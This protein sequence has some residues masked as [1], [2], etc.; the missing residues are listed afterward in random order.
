MKRISSAELHRLIYKK[1]K[2]Y[3]KHKNIFKIRKVKI[4]EPPQYAIAVPRE[5]VETFKL[6]ETQYNLII[7]DSG[8]KIIYQSGCIGEVNK[9][10]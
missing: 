6:I 3:R 7:C 5:I 4:S 2:K 9:N 1:T 8:T 10:G